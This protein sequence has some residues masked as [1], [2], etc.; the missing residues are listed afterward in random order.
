MIILLNETKSCDYMKNFI[1]CA[2][3]AKIGLMRNGLL[4]PQ[5]LLENF[6]SLLPADR[7]ELVSTITGQDTIFYIRSKDGILPVLST[8]Q[9]VLNAFTQFLL[10]YKD[11]IY[12]LFSSDTN[13]RDHIVFSNR[14]PSLMYSLE[15]FPNAIFAIRI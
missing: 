14:F 12:N 4:T 9:D 3:Q 7:Y 13:M 5:C 6:I 1:N 11:F 8:E 10:K 2:M 15:S